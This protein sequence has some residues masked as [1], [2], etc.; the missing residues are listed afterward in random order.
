MKSLITY[1]ILG[2][3]LIVFSL[4]YYPRYK[5]GGGEATI[6]WDVSG[7]YWYLPALFIYKDLKNL[8]LMIVLILHQ[9]Q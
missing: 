1:I 3:G 4:T 6:S 7:Y 2:I 5:Q 8:S 9:P